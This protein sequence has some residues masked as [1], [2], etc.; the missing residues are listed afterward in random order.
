M[1]TWPCTE[2]SEVMGTV[3]TASL[4]TGTAANETLEIVQARTAHTAGCRQCQLDDRY[5]GTY[6]DLSKAFA[7]AYARWERSHG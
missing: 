4:Q 1:S 5:C 3:H 2:K 7:L 6:R